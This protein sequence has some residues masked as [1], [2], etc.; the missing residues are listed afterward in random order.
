MRINQ[1]ELLAPFMKLKRLAVL[2]FAI[3][4]VVITMMSGSLVC[5]VPHSYLFAAL[6]WHMLYVAST[7]AARFSDF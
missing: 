5:F 4:R 6:I 1:V 2:F 7:V 3:S